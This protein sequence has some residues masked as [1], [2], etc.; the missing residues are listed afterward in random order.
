LKHYIELMPAGPKWHA[1]VLEMNGF[2][3]S[4]PITLF[5][6]D[7]LQ[8][9][10]FLFGNPIF[11]GAM[12]YKPHRIFDADDRTNRYYAGV[13]SADWSWHVQ[14]RTSFI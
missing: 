6:R 10:K 9:V 11:A 1:T 5:W 12:E 13:M 14:V 7:S 4:R 8:C 3:T 2:T